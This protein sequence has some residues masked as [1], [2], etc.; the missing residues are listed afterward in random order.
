VKGI[1]AQRRRGI[2][3]VEG[4][5]GLTILS[6]VLAATAA[7]LAGGQRL[8]RTSQD[9]SQLQTDLRTAVRRVARSLRHGFAVVNPSTVSGFGVQASSATQVIVTVPEPSG[10]TPEKVEL[11]FYVS[12]QVLYAQR[13]DQAAPGTA[14]LTGV[15]GLAFSY[16]QTTAAGRT[17]VDATPQLATEVRFTLSAAQGKIVTAM[18]GMACLRNTIAS[19]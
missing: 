10:V 7:L 6:V 13:S 19:S 4:I 2:S 14:L 18:P 5:V 17:A 16:Y 3:L 8:Q 15:R 9:Y 11:R 12:N 1:R